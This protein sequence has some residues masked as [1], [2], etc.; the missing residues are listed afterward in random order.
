MSAYDRKTR[1]MFGVMQS[2]AKEFIQQIE[3]LIEFGDDSK[4]DHWGNARCEAAWLTGL[5]ARFHRE[6]WPKWVA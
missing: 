4:E 1:E 3:N 6:E 5:I 2:S